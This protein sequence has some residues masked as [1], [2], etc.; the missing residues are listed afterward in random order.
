MRRL[1]PWLVL[2]FGSAVS[3]LSAQAPSPTVVTELTVTS[4]SATQL[5]DWDN[6]IEAMRR[7]GELAVRSLQPDTVLND[8]FHERLA[9]C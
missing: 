4:Q 6:R 1:A 3:I 9:G 8:R 7:T 5:R 2:V